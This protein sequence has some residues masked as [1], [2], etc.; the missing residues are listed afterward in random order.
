[1]AGPETQFTKYPSLPLN[2]QLERKIEC[3]VLRRILRND[4]NG[5]SQIDHTRQFY[6]Q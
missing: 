3:L 4:G 5:Q 2:C 6:R 1:M